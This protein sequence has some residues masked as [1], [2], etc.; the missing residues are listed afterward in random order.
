M[1]HRTPRGVAALAA[2]LAALGL[3]ACGDR[4][5][6]LAEREA[7]NRERAAQV[8]ITPGD[9]R[10]AGEVETYEGTPRTTAG[11]GAPAGTGA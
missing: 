2:V 3:A 10:S 7:A 11:L 1:A 4:P 8:H 5:D 6:T 9:N